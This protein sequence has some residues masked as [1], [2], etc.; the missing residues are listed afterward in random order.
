MDQWLKGDNL[1]K[2]SSTASA[3]T[4]ETSEFQ[5]SASSSSQ[6]DTSTVIQTQWCPCTGAVSSKK[7]KYSESYLSLDDISAPGGVSCWTKYYRTV[8]CFLLNFVDVLKIVNQ[9]VQSKTCF[10]LTCQKAFLSKLQKL[11][12]KM[13]PWPP[14]VSYCIV[15][16]G[17]A[18]TPM[19]TN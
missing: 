16:A 1:K 18:R 14:W 9:N 13:R 15:L 3:G 6:S 10:F 17:D 11:T 5:A 8:A 12:M 4:E 7:W 19:E 2:Q